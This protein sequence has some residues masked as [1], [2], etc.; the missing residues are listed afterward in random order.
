MDHIYGGEGDG[1]PFCV[2]GD[3]VC[4][5]HALVVDS[6]NGVFCNPRGT[7]SASMIFPADVIRRPYLETQG[8]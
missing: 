7:T 8:L 2:T 3:S 1:E 5:T 6:S 4:V